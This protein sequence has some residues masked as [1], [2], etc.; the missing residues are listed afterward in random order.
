[1]GIKKIFFRRDSDIYDTCMAHADIYGTFVEE[2]EDKEGIYDVLMSDKLL[3]PVVE[4][5]RIVTLG[6]LFFLIWLSC[7]LDGFWT[8]CQVEFHSSITNFEQWIKN[9]PNI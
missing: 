4:V 5:F 6:F 3:P 8:L 1:M 7:V 9:L 2:E